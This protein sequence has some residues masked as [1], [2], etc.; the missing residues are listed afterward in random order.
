MATRNDRFT[1][2]SPGRLP[3][4]GLEQRARKSGP[5][6]LV[7][8]GQSHY[9]YDQAGRLLGEYDANGVPIYE[10]IHL[11]GLPVG[12]ATPEHS[13]RKPITRLPHH[14]VVTKE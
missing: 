4:N 13:L 11:N 10:T 2:S 9:V 12:V 8:T 5:T 1:T 7:P 3:F 14:A 6:S